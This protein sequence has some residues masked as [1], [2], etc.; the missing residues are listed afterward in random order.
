MSETFI[1]YFCLL[2]FYLQYS[3]IWTFWLHW[4]WVAK[5]LSR[6]PLSV[7]IEVHDWRVVFYGIELL[8]FLSCVISK[9]DKT[10]R[11]AKYFLCIHQTN[12]GALKVDIWEIMY[13]NCLRANSLCLF[14]F[15]RFNLTLSPFT[16]LLRLT[17]F[18]LYS[19]IDLKLVV[20]INVKNTTWR[21]STH[22]IN[23]SFIE[24]KD[25]SKHFD[26]SSKFPSFICLAS[27]S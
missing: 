27:I 6:F 14:S 24:F 7:F 21:S 16:R 1:A 13:E 15:A 17:F 8:L 11:M 25:F 12:W 19:L 10:S 20:L 23:P 2:R 9:D 22:L 18:N 5:I 4:R 26:Q 3:P